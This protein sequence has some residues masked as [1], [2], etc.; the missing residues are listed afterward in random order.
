[1]TVSGIVVETEYGCS[2]LVHVVCILLCVGVP[3]TGGVFQLRAE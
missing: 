2:P 1:M 3:G